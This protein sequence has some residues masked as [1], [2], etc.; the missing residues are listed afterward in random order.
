MAKESLRQVYF[1]PRMA[2]LI[3]LGFASGLPNVLSQDTL[4]AWLTKAGV[5]VT[6]IG[7]FGLVVFPYVFKFLWAPLLD[8]YMP[9]LLGRRRGWLLLAQIG[10][11]AA[12]LAMAIAGPEVPAASNVAPGLVAATQPVSFSSL[13]I[14]GIA[15]AFVVFLSATQDVVADAYRADVLPRAEMGVGSAVFVM[16]YRIAMIVSGT[17]A[18][19]AADRYGWQTAYFLMAAIM[20]L[21]LVVTLFAPEPPL[22]A[23]FKPPTL[24]E[25]VREPLK[26]FFADSG[27]AAALL[28]A[29]V[30]LFRLP[31][32][33]AG[34][35]TTV[36]LIK[37][38]NFTLI[39]IGTVRQAV[40]FFVTILGALVAGGIVARLGMI[41]CLW[42]FGFLQTAS[43]LGFYWLIQRG[44]D[45]PSFVIVI[46][47]ESFC[48]GLVAAGFVAFLM[49]QCD[50]RYSAFQY[51]ILSAIVAATGL[52]FGPAGGWLVSKLDY[53][54]FFLLTVA[55]G[56]P[57]MALLYWLKEPPNPNVDP[58]CGACGYSLVGLSADRLQ[59]PECGAAITPSASSAQGNL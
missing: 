47:I 49:S 28:F 1:N 56:I 48:G 35:M 19:F 42:L 55:T 54:G 3:G 22:S 45:M 27:K 36:L 5:D 18:L 14:L 16:G 41:R 8:A 38:L 17:G 43:N 2:A 32:V 57:G 51:A 30:F 52:V 46:V 50:R 23:D 10:L 34:K 15:A 59:C 33:L 26:Q 6:Q 4:Q 25:A 9:P 37:K 31:D 13:L 12:L 11:V 44:H 29:F 39:E 40:G 7:L 21:S 53:S 20:G 58:V 24:D